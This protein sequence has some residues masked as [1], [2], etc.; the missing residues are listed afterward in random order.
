MPDLTRIVPA[1]MLWKTG[2]SGDSSST[3]VRAGGLSKIRNGPIVIADMYGRNLKVL[4]SEGSW[5]RNLGRAGRGPGEFVTPATVVTRHD[6]LIVYDVGTETVAKLDLEGTQIAAERMTAAANVGQRP[7]VMLDANGIA[8]RVNYEKYRP[9]ALE[10]LS[11]IRG[12]V[13]GTLTIERWN[14][15]DREWSAIVDIDSPEAHADLDRGGLLD[16]WFA[17]RTH[18]A[19]AADGKL[20]L[21]DSRGS[22]I[23]EVL[24][25]GHRSCRIELP[26]E[27]EEV[28]DQERRM[29]HEAQDVAEDRRG[30]LIEA[31]RTA[32]LPSH[33]NAISGLHVATDGRL[34]V[35]GTLEAGGGFRNVWFAIN[36]DEPTFAVELPPG[37][38]IRWTEADVVY[39]VRRDSLNVDWVEAYSVRH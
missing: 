18:W 30:S 5:V 12:L 17:A 36:D 34:W 14:S 37:F 20:L 23:E 39:G 24:L 28:K 4:N 35:G 11:G 9:T 15:A 32:A 29:F 33:K 27:A 16:V 6:T 26:F 10:R 7:D 31:R 25:D 38:A 3:L 19:P 1:T 8:W 22:R 13:R 21:A 2:G